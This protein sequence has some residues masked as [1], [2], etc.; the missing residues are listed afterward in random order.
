MTRPDVHSTSFLPPC[1]MA[2]SPLVPRS[3][4]A[5]GG[6]RRTRETSH[7]T[8][9]LKDQAAQRESEREEQRSRVMEEKQALAARGAAPTRGITFL[10]PSAPSRSLAGGRRGDLHGI[11]LRLPSRSNSVSPSYSYPGRSFN[12]QASKQTCTRSS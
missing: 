1:N 5:Q 7:A 11:S 10:T 9:K 12:W 4:R 3:R 6:Q 2:P 8:Q